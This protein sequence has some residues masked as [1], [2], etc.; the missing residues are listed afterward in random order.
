MMASCASMGHI[1]LIRM[2]KSFLFS[3]IA[4]NKK[5]LPVTPAAYQPVDKNPEELTD[6]NNSYGCG[7]H[8]VFNSTLY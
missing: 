4:V 2:A 8:I 3:A 5:E 1:L 6:D 7:V